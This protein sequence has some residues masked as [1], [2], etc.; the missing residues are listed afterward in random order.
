MENKQERPTKKQFE[1]LEFVEKFIAEH[2][3]GPSYREIMNGCNYS[4]VATVALH[5]NNLI[6]KSRLGKKDRSA[7]SL[8]VIASSTTKIKTDHTV[9]NNEKWLI[10]II[11]N[12]FMQAEKIAFDQPKLDE[13]S[14]LV[15]ALKILGFSAAAQDFADRL[16]QVKQKPQ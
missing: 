14:L 3:Y 2:G 6:K 9:E 16:N 10:G 8:E 11:E 12:K 13:L 5:V 7:R 15:D 4:S 1:L